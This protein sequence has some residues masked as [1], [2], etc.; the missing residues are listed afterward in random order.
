MKKYVEIIKFYSNKEIVWKGDF[1]ANI[2]YAI[3]RIMFAYL[4]WGLIFESNQIVAGFTF[5]T[6]LSYYV[7]N[8]FFSQMD[9]SDGLSKELSK[10]IKTGE[11]NTYL[12][13]PIGLQTFFFLKSSGVMMVKTI[14]NAGILFLISLLG[15]ISL[16]YITDIKIISAAI[17][18]EI[19]AL[20]FMLQFNYYLGLLTIKYRDINVFLKVKNNL[21]LF[22]TGK[23]VPLSLLPYIFTQYA[24][25]FP[26]NYVSYIPSM[27]LLGNTEL[28]FGE[29][30][31]IIIFWITLMQILIIFEWRKCR[32][33][34][35]GVGI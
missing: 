29:Y 4:L 13:L 1:F 35:E 18:I 20:F 34:Y 9:V 5:D 8:T 30:V 16:I 19:L 26:F 24:K 32:K 21:I 11:F 14:T 10:M 22:L 15:K 28:F 12:I 17:V 2:A 7:L 6:M 25:I 23:L 3:T 27:I 31:L 33:E